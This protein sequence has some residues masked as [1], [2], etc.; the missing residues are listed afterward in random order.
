[1]PAG[2]NWEP[3]LMRK[4]P[5]RKPRDD[6]PL[7]RAMAPLILDGVALFR[8]ATTVAATA[9]GE[10][11]VPASTVTRLRGKWKTNGERYLAA[12]REARLPAYLR[13][14]PDV[15][16]LLAAFQADLARTVNEALRRRLFPA[17]LLQEIGRG[18]SCKE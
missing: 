2:N 15:R 1:M 9:A 7:L 6:A 17:K 8:A 5:G 18:N 3:H 14:P 11:C 12:E 13:F 4:K 16:A 10:H